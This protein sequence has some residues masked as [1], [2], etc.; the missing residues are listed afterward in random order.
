MRFVVA[1]LFYLWCGV[2]SAE[3]GPMMYSFSVVCP[4]AHSQGFYVHSIGERRCLNASGSWVQ[5]VDSGVLLTASF[6]C[7]RDLYMAQARMNQSS[8]VDIQCA[9]GAGVVWGVGTLTRQPSALQ[10][11]NVGLV[12]LYVVVFVISV[13]VGFSAAGKPRGGVLD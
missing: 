7:P 1:M 10:L 13:V 5:P 8:L 6:S 3:D 12:V 2:A 11:F 9:T 4:D